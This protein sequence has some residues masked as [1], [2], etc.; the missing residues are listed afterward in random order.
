MARLDEVELVS[1][2]AQVLRHLAG[3]P[4]ECSSLALLGGG[5]ANFVYRGALV[6]PLP[7]GAETV[8]VKHTTGFLACSLDFK[9]DVSRCDVEAIM[10]DAVEGLPFKTPRLLFFDRENKTQVHED[11]PAARTLE[12]LLVSPKTSRTLATAIGRDLGVCLRSFHD[13]ASG[14]VGSNLAGDIECNEPMRQL[15]FQTTYKTFIG[16]LERFPGVVDGYREV[17]EEVQ[18]MAVE[19]FARQPSAEDGPSWGVV[20]GDYWAGNILL[21]DPPTSDASNNLLI[22]DWELSQ[23]GH[24]AYDLGKMFGDLCEKRFLDESECVAWV[25]EGFVE[26]YG[27][28]DEELAFRTAIH[29]GT[30]FI[31][32]CIRRPPNA[33]LLATPDRITDAMKLGRDFIVKGWTKDREWFNGTTLGPLFGFKPL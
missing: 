30:Q 12:P 2:S 26:G 4:Y 29:T 21:I 13:W 25:I 24:R 5:S 3:S 9:I 14:P 32:W 20:H 22:I 1:L 15:K 8:I 27:E 11:F 33:K 28:L 18:A 6:S 7:S 10:L 31:H 16:V 19:E 17:L 23:Y